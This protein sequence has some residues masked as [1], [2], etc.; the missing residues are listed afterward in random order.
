M[1][2]RQDYKLN[3]H[4]FLVIIIVFGLLLLWTLI[5]FATAF[6]AAIMFYVLSKPLIDYLL[7]KDWSKGSIATLVILISFF[8]ILLPIGLIATLLYGKIVAV[9][10]NVDIILE[11]IKHFGEMVQQR[12]NI[13][14]ITTQNLNKIQKFATDVLSFIVNSGFNFFT[15]IS[16]MYFFL[17]FMIQ[18]T[19]RMEAAI[20][21]YLPFKRSKIEVFGSELK[22]QTFSNAVG[23]PAIAVAQGI[24]SYIAYKIVGLEEAGFW[25][26]ITG[27]AS[28]IPIVGASLI[29]M[30]VCV[31]LFVISHTWQGFFL[32]AWGFLVIAMSDNV[33]RFLLAKKMADVHPIVTV[34]GVVIGLDFFGITGLIF[35]PLIISY[36]LILLQIYYVEYQKPSL[37]ER[38]LLPSYLQFNQSSNKKRRRR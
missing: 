4:V 15:T 2:N 3:K 21:F 30:P 9:A 23:V 27:L 37:E 34:L 7:K 1:E 14:I 18:K 24:L 35:G 11:P 22:A 33:I 16:M 32:I 26:I 5:Q 8:I 6:L 38:S 25:S 12:F 31:Y 10:Q 36:F 19:N 13:N 29:W 17:Y 20:V 28:I